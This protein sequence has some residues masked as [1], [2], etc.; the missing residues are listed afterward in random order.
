M[1]KLEDALTDDIEVLINDIYG[2]IFANVP[3]IVRNFIRKSLVAKKV[4]GFAERIT[5]LSQT[6]VEAKIEEMRDEG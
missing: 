1:R 4:K 6:Y 2:D 3:S 5:K